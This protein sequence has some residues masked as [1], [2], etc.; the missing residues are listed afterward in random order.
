MPLNEIRLNNKE[1][2]TLMS[3][4]DKLESR[5]HIV[6]ETIETKY[7]LTLIAPDTYKLQVTT[8]EI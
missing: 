5:Q 1:I 7:E 2:Y 3:L 4:L 6:I 8:K